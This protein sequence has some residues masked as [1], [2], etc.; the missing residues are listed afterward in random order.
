MKYNWNVYKVF[1]NGKR[2]KAPMTTFDATEEEYQHYFEDKVKKNFT[3]SL[4][5]QQYKLIRSDLPQQRTSELVNG[6]EEKKSKEKNRVLGRLVARAGI[7]SK[8]GISTALVYYSETNWR[9][10]WAAVQAGTSQFIAG[11]SPQF[12]TTEE[13][14]S[15]IQ[16]QIS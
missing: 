6:A 3:E 8:R 13:A 1:K 16:K 7:T 4:R 15:W 5:S 11:L 2:A 14:E 12:D 9:W 10:Q